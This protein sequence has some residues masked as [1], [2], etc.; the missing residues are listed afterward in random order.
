MNYLKQKKIDLTVKKCS[1]KTPTR[2][3]SKNDANT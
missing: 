3:L 2:N 1:V